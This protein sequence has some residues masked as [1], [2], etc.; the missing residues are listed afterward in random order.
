MMAKLIRLNKLNSKIVKF[1]ISKLEEKPNFLLAD[2]NKEE[3]LPQGV[4]EKGFILIPDTL[5][6][7]IKA[8]LDFYLSKAGLIDKTRAPKYKDRSIKRNTYLPPRVKLGK[9]KRKGFFWK[10]RKRI[11]GKERLYYES[12]I[13][14]LLKSVIPKVTG[15]VQK[16]INIWPKEFQKKLKSLLS[17]TPYFFR[18]IF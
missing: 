16:P 2:I 1:K 17:N 9:R 15:D 12:A 6:P 4:G 14:I 11:K 13:N 18:N 7:R 3:E 5:N 8:N 10:L